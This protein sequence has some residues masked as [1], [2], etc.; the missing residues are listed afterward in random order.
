MRVFF[1]VASS[2]GT[3][4]FLFSRSP[5]ISSSVFARS[6][7]PTPFLFLIARPSLSVAQLCAYM[8]R[9]LRFCIRRRVTCNGPAFVCFHRAPPR[10]L[11]AR[12]ARNRDR[13]RTFTIGNTRGGKLLYN[14]FATGLHRNN[15]KIDGF[16]NPYC[17]WLLFLP[18]PLLLKTLENVL[19]FTFTY[20]L[21]SLF[22]RHWR[23]WSL[24]CEKRLKIAER[25]LRLQLRSLGKVDTFTTRT[26]V[27]LK[28]PIHPFLFRANA[29]FGHSHIVLSPFGLC[30]QTL[31]KGEAHKLRVA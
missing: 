24:F 20:Q 3:C 30:A 29:S 26:Q 15:K 4:L 11:V 25:S 10:R 19:S 27:T 13:N 17:R 9:L 23:L 5:P 7:E 18:G 22:L 21:Q 8:W 31:T 6:R 16:S 14:T 12:G 28:T 1:P 2:L